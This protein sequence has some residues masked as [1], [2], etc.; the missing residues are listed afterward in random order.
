MTPKEKALV[1]HVRA[2]LGRPPLF[3]DAPHFFHGENLRDLRTIG[4]TIRTPTDGEILASWRNG[5]DTLAIANKFFVHESTISNRLT[6]IR[7]RE[8]EWN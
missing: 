5:C 2:D 1:N 8:P 3:H 7:M 4:R 6:H